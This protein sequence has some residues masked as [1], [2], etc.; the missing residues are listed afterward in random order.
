V[1][2]KLWWLIH[3]DL[4][5]ELRAR[6]AWPAM[7]LLGIVV[8]VVFSVQ[9]DAGLETSGTMGGLLWIAIFFAGTLALERSFGA[10]R[11]QG[12]LRGLLLYPIPPG[13]VYAAK[14]IVNVVALTCL[15]LVL[16]PLFVVFA[17]VPLQ[18]HAAGLALVALLGNLGIAAV[19]TLLGG[20]TSGQAGRANLLA[21]LVLP[22]VVP[23]VLGAAEATRLLVPDELGA[24]WWRWVQLLAA[25]AVVFITAGWILFEYVIE[26]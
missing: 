6:Q 5:C 1:G 17:D 22:V 18:R 16:I 21:L 10:E 13:T 7:L 11:E 25:F 14:L 12:C 23:V 8:A 9:M 20:V 19:G 15:E 4:L 24:A 26:E 2:P 3:K